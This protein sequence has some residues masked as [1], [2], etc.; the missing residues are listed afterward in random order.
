MKK[1]SLLLVLLVMGVAN[2]H[3]DSTNVKT[4]STKIDSL[5]ATNIKDSTKSNPAVP[6]PPVVPPTIQK[7]VEK[8]ETDLDVQR[9]M[10][11]AAERSVKWMVVAAFLSLV[12]SVFTLLISW[13]S[14][15]ASTKQSERV[16]RKELGSIEIDFEN[17]RGIFRTAFESAK[18]KRANLSFSILY[19]GTSMVRL[20]STTIDLVKCDF[21][22]LPADWASKLKAHEEYSHAI[23]L[24]G[25]PLDYEMTSGD[26]TPNE[27]S[28]I[29]KPIE[30]PFIKCDPLC[31]LGRIKFQNGIG[32]TW[33]KPFIFRF[34]WDSASMPQI[35]TYHVNCKPW[36]VYPTLRTD[37]R[38]WKMGNPKLADFVGK[39]VPKKYH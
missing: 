13:V 2:S 28:E 38:E 21:M 5:S 29:V 1:I 6:D 19:T 3:P 32:E 16:L 22:H 36:K 35:E 14:I 8:V 24:P 30:P 20:I 39:L 23:I 33:I 25:K 9:R 34:T 7:T 18:V 37:F 27:W 26:F 31:F 11:V 10:A 12:T 17:S 4:L 15:R